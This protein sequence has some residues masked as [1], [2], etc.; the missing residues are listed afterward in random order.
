[1]VPDRVERLKIG[2][3]RFY[4]GNQPVIH[5]RNDLNPMRPGPGRNGPDLIGLRV[6]K[7]DH[8][9]AIPL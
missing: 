2:V 9:D 3:A 6:L 5:T 4:V 1:M 8:I 7:R